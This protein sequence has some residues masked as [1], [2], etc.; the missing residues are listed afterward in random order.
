M[1]PYPRVGVLTP[2]QN[3][4]NRQLSKLRSTVERAFGLLKGRWRSLR[5]ELNEDIALVSSTI[6]ACCILHNIC[7]DMDD[8]LD[9]DDNDADDHDDDD[10]DSNGNRNA[11]GNVVRDAV[12]Q[13]LI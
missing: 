8:N 3:N 11:A 6:L 13:H 5:G 12:R 9:G 1:K 7:I 10:C 4:F 2:S